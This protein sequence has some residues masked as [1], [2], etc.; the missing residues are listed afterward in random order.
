VCLHAQPPK[1]RSWY[2]LLGLVVPVL[3]SLYKLWRGKALKKALSIIDLAIYI[4]GS[5]PYLWESLRLLREVAE[6]RRDFPEGSSYLRTLP[7][8]STSFGDK[9]GLQV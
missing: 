6:L 9:F 4:A 8:S 1:L 2:V 5:G 7:N 3:D